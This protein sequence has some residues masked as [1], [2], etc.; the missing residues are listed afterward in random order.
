MSPQASA[1]FAEV[2]KMPSTNAPSTFVIVLCHISSCHGITYIVTRTGRYEHITPILIQLHWLPVQY[3]I[4]FKILL[5]VYKA[6]NGLSP[7][8][9]TNLLSYR[10]S[11]RSLRSI[12]NEQLL[13]PRSHTKTYGDRSFSIFAPR[14]WNN[15][16]LDIRKSSCVDYFKKDLK[17]YLFSIFI[18]KESVFYNF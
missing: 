2:H 18:S 3:C 8:Y 13:V 1:E 14:L 7:V 10:T 11:T 5:L 17:T 12:S 4:T 6:L 16:P 9:L 15:I